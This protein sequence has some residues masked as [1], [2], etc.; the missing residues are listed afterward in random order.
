MV[1][2][3]I[4][5]WATKPT[6]SCAV[7]YEIGDKGTPHMHM[8][9]EDANKCRFSALQKLFPTI[10]IEPTRGNKKQAK[11]YIEKK[12]KFEEKNHTVIVPAKYLGDIE[13]KQG[14]RNDLLDIEEMINN[15]M[16]P[17]EIMDLSITFRRHEGLIRKTFFAKRHRETPPLRNVTVYW[18]LGDAGSGKTYEYINLCNEYSEDDVYLLTDYSDGGFDN[19]QGE[20]FLFLDEFKGGFRFQQLLNYLEGYK[21]QIHARYANSFAL[22][23]EVHISSIYSPE[24]VYK[25]M[26]ETHVRQSDPIQQLLRRLNFIV[27]HYKDNQGNYKKYTIEANTYTDYTTLRRLA[28]NTNTSIED[29]FVPYVSIDDDD[30]CPFI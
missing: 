1:D 18:H 23:D 2:K 4:A 24:E 9:L 25:N 27:Y 12:G 5:L 20:K 26:V 30:D 15:G 16:K 6:R 13:G 21:I 11:S 14:K 29:N 19:Y 10:H 8:V 22:W 17:N 3:V 7:N 28:T